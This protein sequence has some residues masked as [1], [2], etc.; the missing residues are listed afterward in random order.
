MNNYTIDPNKV[1]FKTATP[2]PQTFMKK[3]ST[4]S[5]HANTPPKKSSN[6]RP[7][8]AIPSSFISQS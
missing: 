6:R 8:R 2:G 3:H 5:S 1:N 4:T 7:A